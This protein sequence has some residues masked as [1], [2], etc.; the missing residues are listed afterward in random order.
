MSL[1]PKCQKPLNVGD[2][3][4]CR[5]GHA[6]STPPG[7]IPDDIIGGF[8]Q[9][10]FGDK[11]ETFYSKKAMA[12]RAKELG[13]EPMVRNSGPNDKHVPRWATTDPQTMANATALVE[14]MK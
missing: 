1:C 12:L 13:L 4:F 8:V 7:V 6:P 3:P 9:E 5:D 10:H 11:P 2:W 14:R